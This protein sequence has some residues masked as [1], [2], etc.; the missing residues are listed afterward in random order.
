ML[1]SHLPTGTRL[2][3]VVYGGPLS[4][5]G[6]GDDTSNPLAP[7]SG[8]DAEFGGMLSASTRK[9]IKQNPS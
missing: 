5:C 8:T 6:G 9:E 2:T 7:P 3:L 4:P 1:D